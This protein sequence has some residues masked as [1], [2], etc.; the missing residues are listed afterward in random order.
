[1]SMSLAGVRAI[2]FD[3]DDTLTDWWT[4]IAEAAA[5]VG[6]PEIRARVEAETWVRRDGVV[7]NRNHWRTIHE[8]QTFMATDLVEPFLAALDP[9]LFG[10]ALPALSS[11]ARPGAP[12]AAHQQPL[13]C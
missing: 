10:D 7:V 8:P 12:R 13:R 11:A 6:A 3:L 1:M 9:P 4:G 5:T 2:A